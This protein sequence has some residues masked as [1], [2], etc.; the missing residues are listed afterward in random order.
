MPLDPLKICLNL[1]LISLLYLHK[2]VL[3]N[4]LVLYRF[5]GRGLPSILPPIDIPCSDTINGISAVGDDYNVSISGDDFERS[6]DCS[7]F[8]TLVRLPGPW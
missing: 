5:A 6:G 1:Q 8:R 3:N 2:N 7:E 4:V